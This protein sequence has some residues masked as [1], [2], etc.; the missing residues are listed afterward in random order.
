MCKSLDLQTQPHHSVLLESYAKEAV[1]KSPE[2]IL[3]EA[4]GVTKFGIFEKWKACF[5]F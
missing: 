4:R 2:E 3:V 1:P 5:S